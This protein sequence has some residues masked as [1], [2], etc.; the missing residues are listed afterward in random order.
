MILFVLLSLTLQKRTMYKNFFLTFNTFVWHFCTIYKKFRDVFCDIDLFWI[1]TPV[2]LL[3][4]LSLDYNLHACSCLPITRAGSIERA[5]TKLQ[6]SPCSHF[7]LLFIHCGLRGYEI[8]LFKSSVSKQRT[9][10]PK[11]KTAIFRNLPKI[12]PKFLNN[13]TMFEMAV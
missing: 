10:F 2:I 3:C 4:R 7:H 13:E 8:Y 12:F 1:L 9:Q 6:C 11:I 5:G